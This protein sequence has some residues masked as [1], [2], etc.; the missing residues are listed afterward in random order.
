MEE[1]DVE[2]G[3]EEILS[4]SLTFTQKQFDYLRDE[5]DRQRRWVK[6]LSERESAALSEL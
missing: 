6:T 5:F 2:Q 1:G 4:D 3:V